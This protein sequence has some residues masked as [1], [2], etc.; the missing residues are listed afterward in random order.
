MINRKLSIILTAFL[1]CCISIGAEV[2]KETH[3]YA[4]KGADTLRLDKY[5]QMDEAPSKPCLIFVFGGS[6]MR[7]ERDHD[8]Y[9]AFFKHFAEQGYAVVAIDYRL[10]LKDFSKKI[11]TNQG[12]LKMFNAFVDL[13]SEA[14]GMAVEDLFDATGYV[15]QHATEWRIDT[16]RITTCGSSA[17]AVTVLQ[18]EYERCNHSPRSSSLPDGFRYAGVVSFAGAIFSEGKMAWQEKPAPMLFF[19]GDADK[20]VP[21]DRLKFLR[22]GLYGPKQLAAQFDA[23]QAPYLFHT[24]ENAEHEIAT[25]PMTQHLGEIEI[26][27]HKY[28]NSKANLRIRHTETAIGKPELKKKIKLKDCL[29]ANFGEGK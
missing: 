19:H 15:A 22:F 4:I 11:N 16:Q 13:F 9:Q 14:V 5:E 17:G 26:F 28:V 3:I 10:G 18:A 23:M 6:F 1:C 12:K 8:D 7:G 20:N 21:Y 2:A 25:V 27:L 29:D 24:F